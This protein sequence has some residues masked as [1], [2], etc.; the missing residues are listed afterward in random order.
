MSYSISSLDP[1][2]LLN[3]NRKWKIGHKGQL[4]ELD[5]INLRFLKNYF[6]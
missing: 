1:I 3:P 4:K 5:I 6:Y 2:E